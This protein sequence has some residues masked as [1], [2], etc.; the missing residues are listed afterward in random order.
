INTFLIL[1]AFTLGLLLAAGPISQAMTAS[2]RGFL[3][4][5]HDV[6]ADARGFQDAGLRAGIVWMK[7]LAIPAGL[8]I[9]AAIAAG[10][11]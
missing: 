4:H 6:P 2:L 7:A 5:L 1:G 10:L 8:S 11:L 3:A 9:V